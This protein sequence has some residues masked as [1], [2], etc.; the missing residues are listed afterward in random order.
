LPG[1]GSGVLLLAVALLLKAPLAS[2][3]ALTVI[4][5]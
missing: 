4:V 5:A 1:T 3:V 2:T